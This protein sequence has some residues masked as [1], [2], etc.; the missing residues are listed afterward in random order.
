LDVSFV[1]GVKIPD[2]HPVVQ[3]YVVNLRRSLL[4]HEL[5]D[6]VMH[7][8][9]LHEQARYRVR[10]EALNRPFVNPDDGQLA[11]D[12]LRAAA[13]VEWR[14]FKP[15]PFPGEQKAP[16]AGRRLPR[17]AAGCAGRQAG[18]KRDRDA[19]FRSSGDPGSRAADPGSG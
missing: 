19:G 4:T 10:M 14:G 13:K 3:A 5:L 2:L 15:L 16:Q 8:T 12:S 9:A 6:R 17:P 18:A 1:D 7:S 11:V